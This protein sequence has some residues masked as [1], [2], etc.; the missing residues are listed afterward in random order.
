M[1]NY[2][3]V[4]NL[5]KR[6]GNSHEE[7]LK[8]VSLNVGAGEF[9]GLL[10]P[11]AAGKTTLISIMCGLVNITD[12][13]VMVRD[14]NINKNPRKIRS[15][16]GLVP[17]D[18]ALYPSMTIR[19]NINFFGQMYGLKGKK[20]KERVDFCL[21]VVQLGAH[22]GKKVSQCS[23]G[24]MRRANLMAGLIH[25]PELVFLDEPTVGVDAQ[26][27]NLISEYVQELNRAGATIV[28]TTHYMEEAQSLCSRIVI[29]D[30][31][32]IITDGSPARL[33]KEER[34][35]NL[36]EVFLKLTGKELRE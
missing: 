25:E 3:D 24:I 1:S 13:S 6:Y 30:N 33:I 36:G 10:G 9:F 15:L 31:G 18:I 23:G 22:A 16:I 17:Q 28:Y 2:I 8:G 14:I 19:E 11:N 27:R 5:I 32:I 29:I 20:L 26:S 35:L 4:K 7:A 12:G 21:G 34:C